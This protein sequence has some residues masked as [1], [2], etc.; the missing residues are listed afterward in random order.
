[1]T[2]STEGDRPSE[3]TLPPERMLELAEYVSERIVERIHGLPGEPAW[4]GGSRSELE[5]LMREE[6]PEVGVPVEEVID[7]AVRDILPVAG[8]VDHPR[9]FAF[10]PSS[11]TWPGVLA[12]Y[13]A[14][15]HNIF[16]GTWLGASGPS[17]LEVVVIDWFRDWL[18]Y[19]ETAG[20]LFTSG[21]SAASLD[22][23][24]AA[25]EA[26]GAPERATVYMS[27]QSA[28]RV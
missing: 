28:H 12:D 15:G 23:F 18:G 26:A 11:P 9:F 6:P 22:A 17:Q 21:G 7:R 1:M 19:P 4:L 2:A 14:A 3:L 20:G 13:L 24:V 8:R 16:Q 10:V 25:R 5:P 27:D